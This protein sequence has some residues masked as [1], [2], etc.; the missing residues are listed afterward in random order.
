MP[1]FFFAYWAYITVIRA[2]DLTPWPP[3]HGGEGEPNAQGR[4]SGVF[5]FVV[6]TRFIASLCA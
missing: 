6:R 4:Y 2:I 1:P 3:L 5:E